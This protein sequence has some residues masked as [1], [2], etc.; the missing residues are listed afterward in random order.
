MFHTKNTNRLIIPYCFQVYT[1]SLY[2][3]YIV[4]VSTKY[5]LDGLQN[6]KYMYP[7]EEKKYFSPQANK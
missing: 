5:T 1:S 7:K 3:V 4:Y 2:N 6:T